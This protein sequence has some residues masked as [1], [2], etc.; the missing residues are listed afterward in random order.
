MR[1]TPFTILTLAA[2]LLI[3]GCDLGQSPDVPDSLSFDAAVVATDG[4]LEDLR[5]MH[6][7][8]LG[9][10]DIVFPPLVGGRPDCPLSD[11]IFLCPPIERDGLTYTRTITYL[12]ANGTPQD[13]Y[14]EASTASI[15][16]QISVEGEISRD[17]W[18]ASIQRERDLLVTGLLDDDGAVTWNGTGSG[19]VS[20]SRHTDAGDVR[21]YN[22]ISS[23]VI[24]DVVLPYP[25]TEDGWPLSG[26]IT[27]N[28]VVTRTSDVDGTETREREVTVTFDG[29]Q[30][31]TVTVGD[32]TFSVDLSERRFGPGKMHRRRG[33][34]GP[35]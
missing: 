33:G 12:D 23:A 9:L 10:P 31:A 18:S 5:M 17:R 1:S 2:G 6:G 15:H 22:I 25:R 34:H 8:R 19:N 32:E 20:R 27:R 13:A 24:E 26:A 14:D 4:T 29:T 30:F 35:R 16:Y 3:A 21:T 11:D 7:P 28:M